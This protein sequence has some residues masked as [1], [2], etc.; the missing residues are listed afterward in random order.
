MAFSWRRIVRPLLGLSVGLMLAGMMP[1]FAQVAVAPGGFGP[2]GP[3]YGGRNRGRQYQGGRRYRGG[4]AGRNRNTNP[5]GANANGGG[6]PGAV[7]PAPPYHFVPGSDIIPAPVVGD[8]ARVY[9]VG[10]RTVAAY[11]KK[12]GKSLWVFHPAGEV[13][14]SPA[15]GPDGTVYVTSYD[16]NVYALDGA[17]GAKKWQFKTGDLVA[18]TPAVAANGWV[19]VGGYDHNIYALDASGAKK[20]QI[21]VGGP[22]AGPAV[23]ADGTVYVGADSVYAVDG[24]T[25]RV[26]WEFADGYVGNATPLLDPTTDAVYVGAFDGT[27]YALS[28]RTGRER[29]RV[30]LPGPINSTPALDAGGTLYV[31]SDRLYALTASDGRERWS[32]GAAGRT[33]LQWSS[34]V[35]GADGRVYAG[36]SDQSLYAFSASGG[37]ARWSYRATGGLA[38]AP[39]V[40]PTGRVYLGSAGSGVVTALDPA[41]GRPQWQS[42]PLPVV[43]A[44]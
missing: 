10:Y 15:V 22:V 21:K 6:R 12:T 32:A 40:G 2:G 17:T 3:V 11:D 1:V 41:S 35:V 5:G 26:R 13:T 9:A 28:L 24:A 8:A 34:P 16:H 37:R 27:V 25:G 44:R 29:W 33:D 7:P 38:P 19:Y 31:G 36:C 18:T 14:A 20:W 4:R 42:Q 43:A 39:A 30:T 23:G